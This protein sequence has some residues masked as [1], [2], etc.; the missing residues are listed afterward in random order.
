MLHNRVHRLRLLQLKEQLLHGLNGVVAQIY[1]HLFNLRRE[2]GNNGC[3]P[4]PHPQACRAP[5]SKD[6]GSRVWVNAPSPVTLIAHLYALLGW[7]EQWDCD[8]FCSCAGLVGGCVIRRKA[9]PFCT[10]EF[11]KVTFGAHEILSN[12]KTCH[13]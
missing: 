7:T 8:S 3:F 9:S 4:E 1:C 10:T 13:L 2:T 6:G 12:L 11:M 5:N